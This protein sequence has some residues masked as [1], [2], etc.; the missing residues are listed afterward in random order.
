MKVVAKWVA[1]IVEPERLRDALA[2]SAVLMHQ[3]VMQLVFI[4]GQE[5]LLQAWLA[6]SP[7]R[8]LAT[9]PARPCRPQAAV[10]GVFP[11]AA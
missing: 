1:V 8:S 10:P 9:L 6:E 5:S 7:A 3:G 11:A 4:E 2:R